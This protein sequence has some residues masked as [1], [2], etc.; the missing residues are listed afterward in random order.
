MTFIQ[1][2]ISFIL[3]IDEHLIEIIQNFGNWS[4]VIL[5]LIVFVETGIVIFLFAG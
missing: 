1:N 4:Y 2:I 5:F 3:H